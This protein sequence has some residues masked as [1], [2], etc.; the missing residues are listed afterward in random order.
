MC[1]RDRAVGSMN[2]LV[3]SPRLDK[4]ICYTIVDINYAKSGQVITISSPEK[5][6]TA[7]TV[8]LPW[9]ERA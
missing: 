2:A 1:I 7:R 6:L 9:L 5:E 4:N 3:Y 8:D